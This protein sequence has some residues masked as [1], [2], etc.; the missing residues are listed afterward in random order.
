MRADALAYKR[1]TF[2]CALPPPKEKRK[3]RTKQSLLGRPDAQ[4]AVASS[5]YPGLKGNGSVYD[6]PRT[7]RG[8]EQDKKDV[9]HNL[10]SW[11]GAPRDP[12]ID[13]DVRAHGLEATKHGEDNSICRRGRKMMHISRKTSAQTTQNEKSF[14]NF[15]EQS[16]TP[17]SLYLQKQP[18]TCTGTV[19]AARRTYINPVLRFRRR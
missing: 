14:H 12:Q 6:A 13:N 11:S 8:T 3:K 15:R 4:R 2:Q 19:S 1:Q 17:F 18:T 16:L 9:R 7:Q 5:S 10:I